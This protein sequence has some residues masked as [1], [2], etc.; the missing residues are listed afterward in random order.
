MKIHHLR[1]ENFRRHHETDIEFPDGVLAVLGRNGSGKSTLVEAI[2]FALFG[3]A[4]TRT[5]KDLLRWDRAAPADPVRVELDC[6]IAGRAVR[7]E[8]E[9]RGKNLTGTA[10]LTVDGTVQVPGGAGSH[11]AVTESIERMLGMGQDAFFTTV[12]ARQRE[13]SRLADLGPADRKRLILEML[14]VDAL[15]RAIRTARGRG[16]D[17]QVRVE[18]LRESRPDEKALRTTVTAAKAAVA[19]TA[20]SAAAATKQWTMSRATLAQA[21]AAHEAKQAARR[22]HDAAAARRDAALAEVRQLEARVADLDL[23]IAQAS[24]ADTAAARLHPD[25]EQAPAL[26]AALETVIR[27]EESQKRRAALQQ[28][29][30]RAA[31]ARDGVVVPPDPTVIATQMQQERAAV[32]ETLRAA[33]REHAVREAQAALESR[34]TGLGDGDACPLCEQP[35]VDA[36]ALHLRLQ[37]DARAHGDAAGEQRLGRL[38]AQER[39]LD[40]MLRGL[41]QQAKR[42]AESEVERVRW[43]DRI[44]D[45][46]ARLAELPAPAGADNDRGALAAR[47]AAAEAA[48][49]ERERA[50][51]LAAS[52]G[53]LVAERRTHGGALAGLQRSVA[54]AL[55]EITAAGYDPAA[56]AAARATWEEATRAERAAERHAERSAAVHEQA[57]READAATT[58]LAEAAEH[59]RRLAAAEQDQTLWTGLADGRGH[60]LLER[61]KDHLVARIGPAVSA[62]ASRLLARFTDGRYTEVL[63]DSEYGLYVA[64]GGQRYTLERFS[65]GETD[66]VHL[67]LRLAV[68]RLV[69][70]RA[71]TDLRFLALDEVFGSLDDERRGHVLAALQGLRGLYSQVLLVTHQDALRDALDAVLLVEEQDGRAVVTMHHG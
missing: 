13:L 38:Q 11:Q 23:R 14:G 20:K 39:E 71:G 5:V 16:R 48:A 56:E 51:A 9:L 62:E 36:G 34:L 45:L 27:A 42:R 41:E 29:R 57:R 50:L 70:D 22:A 55:A 18:T 15:D 63:L 31:A 65:G 24:A 60:G 26:R 33:E 53:R 64:D 2:G 1:L 7:I 25:A 44:R 4:A 32:A 3:T 49:R 61:F 35:I 21:V 47:L 37:H 6:E 19:A 17:A 43:Q 40:A 67:A 28:E 52:R 12:V 54:A 46:D 69:L 10:T 58:R 30:A 66:L 8:R 59:A 68:S